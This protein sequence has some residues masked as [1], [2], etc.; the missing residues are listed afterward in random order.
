M[1][2]LLIPFLLPLFRGNHRS[3]CWLLFPLSECHIVGVMQS[4]SISDWL[5]S[6]SD[7]HVRFLHI[8]S[9]MM[10]FCVC[11]DHLCILPVLHVSFWMLSL[12]KKTLSMCA[13]VLY[14]LRCALFELSFLLELLVVA[15][16]QTFQCRLLLENMCPSEHFISLHIIACKMTECIS[17]TFLIFT[18]P[19]YYLFLL[20]LSPEY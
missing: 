8:F 1:L 14:L 15:L 9:H 20:K 6:L 13:F 7:M 5:Y 10:L 18:I 2:H 19:Y 4:A 17:F 16:Q 3:F 11:F 12:Q